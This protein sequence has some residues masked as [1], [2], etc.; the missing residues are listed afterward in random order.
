MNATR[1]QRSVVHLE[2]R[3]RDWVADECARA[4]G[5]ET[6]GVL[7]LNER[8]R[9]GAT[10]PGR[11]AVLASDTCEWDAAWIANALATIPAAGGT[12]LGRWHKHTAPILLA[13]DTDKESARA[14]LA[15]TGLPEMLDLIVA[16]GEHDVPI[17]WAVYVCTP[18]EYRRVELVWGEA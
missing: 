12:I 4:P 8:G 17:G 13:S 6:C 9:A 3:A 11:H 14:F 7:Y 2:A 18:E 15:A 16:C 10:G 5:T 1:T